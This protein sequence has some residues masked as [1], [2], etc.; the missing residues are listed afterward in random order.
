MQQTFNRAHREAKSKSSQCQ[1]W[2]SSVLCSEEEELEVKEEERMKE[3]DEVLKNR[4]FHPHLQS[5]PLSNRQFW[6]ALTRKMKKKQ[7]QARDGFSVSIALYFT[8]LY[9]FQLLFSSNILF[10]M[11]LSISDTLTNVFSK[12]SNNNTELN[13]LQK[14]ICRCRRPSLSR[15]STISGALCGGRGGNSRWSHPE[16]ILP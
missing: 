11:F 14:L 1:S 16:P 12:K 10:H 6:L 8:S 4:F 15:V 5:S 7:R 2:M 3:Q 9:R 13:V